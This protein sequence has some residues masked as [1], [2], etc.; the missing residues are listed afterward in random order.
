MDWQGKTA[1]ITGASSGIG[2]A[3]ARKLAQEKLRVVAVARRLLR[4]EALADEIQGEGGQV[5]VI[6]A[7]LGEEAERRRVFDY[8]KDAFG[9]IDVLINNA[10]FGWYGYGA[11]MPWETAKDMLQVNV[12]AVVHFSLLF[13]RGMLKRDSGHIINVGSISGVLPSQGIALYGATKS[14]LDN[15]TTA[16]YREVKGTRVH[17]SVVR[18]GPV[19]SEFGQAAKARPGGLRVPTE[20]IGVTTQAVAE[21]IW[22]LLQSPK[23][24]VYIPR[25]LAV[26]PW[27]ENLFGWLIDRL[28]PLLLRRERGS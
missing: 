12:A 14:F 26:T 17:L 20:R 13:L 8:I 1:L 27:V 28:G 25:Y 5:A 18:A 6:Q 19:T 3:T 23:R 7:D 11:E 16:L 4:L 24:A 15:F 2:E 21:R 10:G 9:G 22:G